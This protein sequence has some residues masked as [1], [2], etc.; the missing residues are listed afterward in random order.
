M[1]SILHDLKERTNITINGK[2]FMIWKVDFF[3]NYLF[4][5]SQMRQAGIVRR[6]KW[7]A[8]ITWTLATSKKNLNK[9]NT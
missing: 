3:K 9:L 8:P 6:W 1:S 2:N 5:Q 7:A 4:R